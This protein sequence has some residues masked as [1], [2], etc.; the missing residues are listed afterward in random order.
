MHGSEKKFS[1]GWFEDDYI[2]SSPIATV[3]SPEGWISAF[4]NLVTEYQ[5]SEVTIDLMRHRTPIENGTMEYLFANL[6]LWAK[7]QGCHSFNLGL[8]A[9]SGVGEQADDPAIER[10]M[11]FIYENV[12]QFYNFKGLH[13]FKEKFNP[14][15]SP[16]YL[17]YGGAANLVPGWLAVTQA[18]SGGDNLLYG[19][20]KRN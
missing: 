19:Y 12:S 16:R 15:W 7:A 1:L 4:A 11:H 13:A 8:S 6:F 14:E 2:R 5:A 20:L 17:I 10:V 3:Y 9:L 18:N